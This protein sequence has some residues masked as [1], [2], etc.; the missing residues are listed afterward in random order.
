MVTG[1]AASV[2]I[3]YEQ[4]SVV[5]KVTAF[6]AYIRLVE[7]PAAGTSHSVFINSIRLPGAEDALTSLTESDLKIG[8]SVRASYALVNERIVILFLVVDGAKKPTFIDVQNLANELVDSSSRIQKRL[9]KTIE[10]CDRSETPA[11]LK[12]A[13]S[14]KSPIDMRDVL[15]EVSSNSARANA[16]PTAG[17]AHNS[18]DSV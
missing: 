12:S 9:V 7:G 2:P 15:I 10:L 5:E 16:A 18:G 3:Y 8:Q 17:T 14:V 13:K 11:H 4:E 6:H 1:T